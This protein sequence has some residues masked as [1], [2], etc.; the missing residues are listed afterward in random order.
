MILLGVILGFVFG[1][2]GVIVFVITRYSRNKYGGY[3]YTINKAQESG[4]LFLETGF[5][6]VARII[7][8]YPHNLLP[9]FEKI[10]PWYYVLE[11]DVNRELKKGRVVLRSKQSTRDCALQYEQYFSSHQC[12]QTDIEISENKFRPELTAYSYEYKDNIYKYR[13]DIS[14]EVNKR[15]AVIEIRVRHKK[16]TKSFYY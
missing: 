1:V 3:T 16:D 8:Q 5:F 9:I 15:K 13:I 12:K 4:H 2:I 6:P 10:K 7:K 11:F 14:K